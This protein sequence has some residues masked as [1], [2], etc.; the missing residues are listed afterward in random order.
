[1]TTIGRAGGPAPKPQKRAKNRKRNDATWREQCLAVRGRY[2]RACI[3]RSAPGAKFAS[4]LQVDHVM[5]RSQGGPS[6]LGNG[7]VLCETHH[8]AKTASEILI[9]YG[10]LDPDQVAWLEVVG[11]VRWQDDGTPA[12]RGWKHFAARA[13]A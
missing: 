12:G 4:R 6:V 7:L 11:W 8:M 13:V 1:M 3:T 9:E 2:C 10:W 5:P